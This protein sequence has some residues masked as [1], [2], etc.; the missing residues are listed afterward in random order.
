MVGNICIKQEWK[1]QK[2]SRILIIASFWKINTQKASDWIDANFQSS[3]RGILQKWEKAYYTYIYMFEKL[4]QRHARRMGKHEHVN[5]YQCWHF[6]DKRFFV[7]AN[8]IAVPPLQSVYS[9]LQTK[10]CVRYTERGASFHP[11]FFFGVQN[12]KHIKPNRTK[13][14][15]LVDIY[16]LYIQNLFRTKV[17]N[18]EFSAIIGL[19]SPFISLLLFYLAS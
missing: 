13:P 1:K 14:N 19:F 5:R 4:E 15:S 6:C 2:T 10:L 8:Q 16:I 12:Q 9:C 18:C 7:W 11:S 17:E 3:N